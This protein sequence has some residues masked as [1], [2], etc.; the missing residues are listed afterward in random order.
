MIY[1]EL[2]ARFVAPLTT[3]INFLQEITSAC[4]ILVKEYSCLRQHY[5]LI[6]FTTDPFIEVHCELFRTTKLILVVY[7]RYLLNHALLQLVLV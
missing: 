5:I 1:T 7:F 6:D 3:V 2:D 4:Q